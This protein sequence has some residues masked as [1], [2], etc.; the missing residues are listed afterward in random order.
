MHNHSWI[1]TRKET[2][3]AV[4]ETFSPKVA[5]AINRTKYNVETALDYL[6][7]VNAEIKNQQL[8]N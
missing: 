3:A 4:L 8:A 2:G 6:C 5:N 1:V 7:R